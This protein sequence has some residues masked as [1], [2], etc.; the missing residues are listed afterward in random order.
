M[1]SAFVLINVESGAEDS[2][3]KEVKRLEVVKEAYVSYGVYD[4]IVKVKIATMHELKEN[5]T[6]KI[7]SLPGVRSTL[8]LMVIEE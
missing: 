5:V 1:P 7:R 6:H 8:T 3:L 2:V 4:V